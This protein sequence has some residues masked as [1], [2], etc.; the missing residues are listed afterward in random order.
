MMQINYFRWDKKEESSSD[1]YRFCCQMTKFRQWVFFFDVKNSTWWSLF[2]LQPT[3][4][5]YHVMLLQWVQVPWFEWFPNSREVTVAWSLPL[6]ARLVW[7]KPIC[8]LYTGISWKIFRDIYTNYWLSL[9]PKA[10]W[11]LLHWLWLLPNCFSPLVHCVAL[12]F[13][14][15]IH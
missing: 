2:I 4:S 15:K 7:D 10:I 8:C 12:G 14:F 1:F 5:T 3:F 9:L 11:A 13:S 6:C